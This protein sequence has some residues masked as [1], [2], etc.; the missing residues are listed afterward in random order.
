[1]NAIDAYQTIAIVVMSL[2]IIGNRIVTA[3]Q[4]RSNW[5]AIAAHQHSV[6][7]LGGTI[8]GPSNLKVVKK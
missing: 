2:Y 5:K 1:M 7:P 4:L 3:R 6:P 8:T